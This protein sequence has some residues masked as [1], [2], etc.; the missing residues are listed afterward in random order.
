MPTRWRV[1]RL[2]R[3][4]AGSLMAAIEPFGLPPE[5]ALKWFR[6]KGYALTFDW[7]DLWASQHARA[8]TVAKAT[9]L[10]VLADIREALDKALAGGGTLAEFKKGLRPTLQR[11]GWWGEKEEVDP[12]TGESRLVQLG[13]ANRLR[14]I[15]ETNLRSAQS[16]GRWERMQ[17]TKA[18]RPYARYV[19]LLDGNERAQ[20]RAWHG[21]ILPIDD[22]WWKT[23]A[24]PNGWGCRC[25][26]QQLSQRDLERFGFEVSAKAPPSPMRTWVNERTG[27]TLRIPAGIDPGFEFN[28]GDVPRGF[29]PPDNAPE[30]E[31]RIPFRAAGRPTAKELLA[32]G[33]L[34]EAVERW[35]DIKNVN[36]AAARWH[37]LFGKDSADVADPTGDQVTFSTKMLLHVMSKEPTRADFVPRAKQAVEQPTEIWLVPHRLADGRV[38][39]RKRYIGIFEGRD[40]SVVVVVQRTDSGH[41]AWTSY[42]TGRVD[43]KREG[44]LLWPR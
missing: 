5:E 44:Y 27:K 17:R 40:Q 16:A 20:H 15:Y 34:P 21:T 6:E 39:M 8:F 2:S 22:P 3:V 18:A 30:L 12:L 26:M 4:D 1:R 25:K 14:T 37:A 29:T 11:K 23:H 33:G 10:D 19:C 9:Q 7:R 28:P 31:P 42:P 13:S 36:D 38:V 41:A 24:P 43:S 32:K 35:H